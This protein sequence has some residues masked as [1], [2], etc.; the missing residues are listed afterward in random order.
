MTI[1]CISDTHNKHEDL[2]IPEGDILIHAGDITES[3]TKRE[4]KSFFE[5]FKNQP[6][7]HKICIAGN[8]DFYLRL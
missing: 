1:I 4:L 2:H 3:G 8:H 7:K 6:H 5:W